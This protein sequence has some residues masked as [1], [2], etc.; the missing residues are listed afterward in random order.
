MPTITQHAPGT[1]SWPELATTDPVAAKQFYATLLGW[2]VQDHDMGVHG[3]YTVFRLGDRDV[4]ACTTLMDA[5]RAAGIPPHWLSYATVDDADAA[6]ARADAAGGRIVQPAFEA[7]DLGRM[8]VIADPSGGVF[9]VWQPRKHIGAGTLGE[10]GALGWTQLNAAEPER[11]KPFYA[12]VFGWTHRDDPMPWGGTYTTWLR[13]DG[14]PAGGMMPMPP[15]AGMPSHW[16]SYF[17]TA[18]V[19]ASHA[20]AVELGAKSYVPPTDL[21]GGGRFAVLADPQGATFGLTTAM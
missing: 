3:T 4:S 15:G 11:V 1:F 2:Q 12:S 6:V 8:A 13:A 20:K 5:L 9:A 7:S 10:P 17:V 19:D 18:N 21:P 14:T 16:L